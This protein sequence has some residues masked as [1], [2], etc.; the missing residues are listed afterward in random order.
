MPDPTE[1]EAEI[2][3]VEERVAKGV[4]WLNAADPDG[5]HYFRWKH[6][7]LRAH[8]PM[9][10]LSPEDREAWVRYATNMELYERLMSKLER[11]ERRRTS[12][13][14]GATP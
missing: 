11:L 4:A 2:A 14:A 13:M 12:A 1:L 6:G 8:S 5:G 3:D 9:P 10:G 7:G